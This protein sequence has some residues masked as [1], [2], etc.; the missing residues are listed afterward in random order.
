LTGSP[1]CHDSVEQPVTGCAWHLAFRFNRAAQ[2]RQSTLGRSIQLKPLVN[3]TKHP[4]TKQF[5][6]SL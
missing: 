2:G 3:E 4:K 6:L 5:D 1:A